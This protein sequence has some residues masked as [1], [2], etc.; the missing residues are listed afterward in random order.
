MYI[1]NTLQLLEKKSE[2]IGKK[3]VEIETLLY[4]ESEDDAKYRNMYLN[5]W[6]RKSS[7]SLNVQFFQILFD[8]KQK[9]TQSKSCDSLVKEGI[10]NNMKYFELINLTREQ[11]KNKL[12]VKT[13]TNTLSN[14]EE[15]KT[16][17]SELEVL[18]GLKVKIVENVNKIF[19]TLNEDNIIT[20]MIKVLQKKTTEQAIIAENK[21]KYENLIKA[22]EEIHT[23]IIESKNRISEKNEKFLKL[24]MDSMKTSHENEK[25]CA[26]LESYVQLYNQKSS[27]LSQGLSFYS[28]FAFRV[29]LEFQKATDFVLARDTEK[30]EI[31]KN[32]N[33]G[34]QSNFNN[35]DPFS[36]INLLNPSTNVITNMDYKYHYNP[37]S[38]YSYYNTNNQNKTNVNYSNNIPPNN[39]VNQSFQNNSSSAFNHPSYNPNYNYGP[40]YNQKK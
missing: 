29:N 25:F 33:N 19:Q 13:D 24:K 3:I 12:P 16:L 36:G 37:V 8:Y 30:N 31:I 5:R 40:N 2:E 20:Q 14:S 39:Q 10:V 34:T 7:Q 15:A 17:N 22:V 23:L 4:N 27:G 32:L 6:T 21:S 26:D 35:K 9:L 38:Q 1:T 18:E 28:D 11:L